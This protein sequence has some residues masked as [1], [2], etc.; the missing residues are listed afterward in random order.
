MKVSDYLRDYV[1]PR[2]PVSEVDHEIA[3]QCAGHMRQIM[4]RDLEEVDI[5]TEAELFAIGT[6][7]E[8]M[9]AAWD[10]LNPGERAAWKKFVR[11]EEWLRKAQAGRDV[12]H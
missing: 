8:V 7:S 2:G 6:D 3:V 10:H 12:N 5:A 4:N 11:Y 1:D 9:M